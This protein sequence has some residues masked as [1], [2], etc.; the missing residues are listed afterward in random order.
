MSTENPLSTDEKEE[1]REGVA[2]GGGLQQKSGYKRRAG[3]RGAPPHTPTHTHRRTYALSQAMHAFAGNHSR[4]GYAQTRPGVMMQAATRCNGSIHF[5]LETWK[6]GPFI[7]R[8]FTRQ[9]VVIE[10]YV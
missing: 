8:R 7:F 6:I 4:C 5:R 9:G 10:F 1:G 2:D 3:V